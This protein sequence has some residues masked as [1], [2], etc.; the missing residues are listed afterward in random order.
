MFSELRTCQS[1][2]NRHVLGRKVDLV[3]IFPSEVF[4]IYGLTFYTQKSVRRRA[5]DCI[6]KCFSK[7]F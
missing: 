4:S 5:E 6:K 7:P 3:Y 2:Q 1:Y